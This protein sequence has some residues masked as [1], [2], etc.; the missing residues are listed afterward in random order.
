MN[1]KTKK[2]IGYSVGIV[3]FA[4]I[5][6]LAMSG[7]NGSSDAVSPYSASAL[8][9]SESAFSF[10]NVPINGGDVNHE[11]VARNDG[12]ESIV[13]EKVYTSCMCTTVLITDESG[14][15]YGNFGMPGHGVSSDTRI[16]V[17]P[18]ESVTIMAIYDP[19]AHGPSGIGFADRSIYLET[20]S[21]KSPK[22]ELSFQA[23]VTP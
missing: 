11:F 3:V 8:T 18:G 1:K 13:I 21:A 2:Q 17:R 9:A 19:A 12:K 10:G 20:N 23:T 4:A 6:F 7:G 14:K 15:N 5:A 22:L 16:E